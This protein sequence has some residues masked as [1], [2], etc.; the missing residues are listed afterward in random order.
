M[1]GY[2]SHP[3]FEGLDIWDFGDAIKRF[4]LL[5]DNTW[6]MEK[7]SDWAIGQAPYATIDTW[8]EAT[9]ARDLGGYEWEST[10]ANGVTMAEFPKNNKGK[11]EGAVICLG[12]IAYDWHVDH[13]GLSDYVPNNFQDRI[14]ILTQKTLDYLYNQ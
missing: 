2:E 1:N 14:Q 3:I 8:R 9:G 12:S 4:Y 6:R 11:G 10:R 13:K 5:F 7:H